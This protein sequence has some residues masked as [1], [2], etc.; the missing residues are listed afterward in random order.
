MTR[1]GLLAAVLISCVGVCAQQAPLRAARSADERSGVWQ[2]HP[3]A[4]LDELRI[5][6]DV[7]REPDDSARDQTRI[8]I[9][10]LF[11]GG[12]Q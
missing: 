3:H 11:A 8:L 9:K 12:V 6:G 7:V 4:Q 1:S 2:D 10:R 5:D